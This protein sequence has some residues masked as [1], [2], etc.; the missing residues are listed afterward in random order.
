MSSCS[1]DGN[2][3]LYGLGIRL[4]IYFQIIATIL[5]NHFVPDEV[6]GIW[7]T[8]GIFTLAVFAAV[9]NATVNH[10]IQYIEAFVMLQLLFAFLLASGR[11]S[12]SAR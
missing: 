3:D 6:S 12:S 9:A 10:V 1:I 7:D 11:T 2:P 5:V 4:G 8:N